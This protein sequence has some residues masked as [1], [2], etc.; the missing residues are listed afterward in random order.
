[1]SAILIGFDALHGMRRTTKVGRS[2]A[3]FYC[4]KG[5]S[6]HEVYSVRFGNF[7]QIR[8]MKLSWY[9]IIKD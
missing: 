8:V 6:Y 5:K 2:M 9:N 7:V 3:E 1:M 4:E